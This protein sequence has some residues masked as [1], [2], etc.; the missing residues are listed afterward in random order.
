MHLNPTE[1]AIRVFGSPAKLCRAIGALSSMPFNWKAPRPRTRG[2][3]GDIPVPQIR[4]ILVAAKAQGLDLTEHDL[5]FGRE[6]EDP[7]PVAV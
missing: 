6:V 3:R 1:Y 7:Q 5:L 4:L 2:E